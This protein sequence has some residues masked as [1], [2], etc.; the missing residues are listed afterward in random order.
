MSSLSCCLICRKEA[1]ECNRYIPCLF[2]YAA[3]QA[4]VLTTYQDSSGLQRRILSKMAHRAGNDSRD[5]A[6]ANTHQDI[7]PFPGPEKVPEPQRHAPRSSADA[8]LRC[9]HYILA[10][11]TGSPAGLLDHVWHFQVAER[12]VSQAGEGRGYTHFGLRGRCLVSFDNGFSLANASLL[13]R[14][15]LARD[16]LCSRV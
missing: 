14:S 16:W 4:L 2:R 6:V 1:L 8:F 11:A 13:R 9:L 10:R 3:Q 15:M 7:L 5:H 12:G